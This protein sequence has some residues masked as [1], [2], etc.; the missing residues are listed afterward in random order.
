M[1]KRITQNCEYCGKQFTYYK[2]PNV[3][4]RFC[5]R[6]CLL[7]VIGTPI[8][9]CLNCGKEFKATVYHGRKRKFCSRKCVSD[10][11]IRN[12]PHIICEYC[13]NIFTCPSS[14]IKQSK[15]RFCSRACS[16]NVD[17]RRHNE[18]VARVIT[19]CA[20]CG[21]EFEHRITEKKTYCSQI[22]A[23]NIRKND[24]PYNL[25]LKQTSWLKLRKL[26][27]ERDGNKCTRCGGTNHLSVHHKIPWR[28]SHNDDPDNL[29]TVCAN[30]HIIIEGTSTNKMRWFKRSLTWT[31]S[32][33]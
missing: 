7:K 1:L 28:K 15:P 24:D 5:S 14:R 8:A 9:I 31:Q 21:K 20:Q 29:V 17:F 32:P 18:K 13:G 23:N 26:I 3:T 4:T 19:V 2:K 22:C 11:K 12:R 27:L 25:R 30:C 6:D 10:Y 33:G 16:R